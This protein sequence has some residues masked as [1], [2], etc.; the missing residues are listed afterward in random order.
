MLILYHGGASI[1]S[2]KVRLALAEK[3]VG[4]ESRIAWGATLRDPEYLKLNPNGVVPTLVH[5]EAVLIESRIISEYVN[6]AFEGPALMPAEPRLRHTA[7]LWSKQSDDSLHLNVYILSF[8]TGMRELFRAMP[9]P[10]RQGA[11]P[12]LRDPIKRQI[13]HDLM[14][15]GFASPHARRALE[16]FRH[17]VQEMEIALAKAPYLAGQAYSLADADLTAYLQRLTDLGLTALWAERPRLA[18][19]L[20]RMQARPSFNA[21]ILDWRTPSEVERSRFNLEATAAERAALLAAL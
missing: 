10:V 13:T 16:R 14:D 19:W 8:V 9:E 4:W 15:Q 2:Q 1:A 12:G 21:A 18:D 20:A 7:R 11:L 17:L 6:D 5:D 3:G